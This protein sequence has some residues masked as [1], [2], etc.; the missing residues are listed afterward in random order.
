MLK[1]NRND[2]FEI[3]QEKIQDELYNKV[4]ELFASIPNINTTSTEELI[5]AMEKV[6]NEGT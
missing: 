5:K 1:I 4:V 3:I 2:T 6:E